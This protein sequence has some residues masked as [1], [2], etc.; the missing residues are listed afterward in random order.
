MITTPKKGREY[1]YVTDFWERFYTIP[2]TAHK[3]GLKWHLG[4][5]LYER[6][7]SYDPQHL[8]RKKKHAEAMAAKLNKGVKIF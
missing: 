5:G 8:F 4:D 6:Y 3:K 7:H 2:V 1:W